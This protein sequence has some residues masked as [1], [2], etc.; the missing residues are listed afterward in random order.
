MTSRAEDYS[1]DDSGYIRLSQHTCEAC[2]QTHPQRK[3]P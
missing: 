1:D 3:T 2:G